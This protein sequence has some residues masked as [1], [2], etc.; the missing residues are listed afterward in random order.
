MCNLLGGADMQKGRPEASIAH[1]ERMLTLAEQ[2][3]WQD[4]VATAHTNLATVTWLLGGLRRSAEHLE[5]ATEIDRR[6]G[7]PDG[8]P[9]VLIT[10]GMTLRDLGRLTDSLDR[11]Q[12]AER[13]PK[14]LDSQHN[15]IQ[16]HVNLGWTLHLLGDPAQAA[17]H[18]TVGLTM[19]RERG[20]QDSEAY[21]LRLQ[22]SLHRDAGDLTTALE[23]ATAA[24]DLIDQDGED[25]YRAATRITLGSV[26][27]SLDRP[28]EADRVH[29]EAL[30]L[31]EERGAD[32]LRARALLGLA[33]VTAPP[34]REQ[35]SRALDIARGTEHLLVEAEALTALARAELLHGEA[36]VAA[37]HARDAL[38]VHRSTGHR[39][40]QADTLDILG[41]AVATTGE[42]D[43][44]PYRTEAA[45]IF[46]SL[47]IPRGDRDPR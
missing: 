41:R 35:I 10:L 34:D 42:E 9:V 1:L 26:L 32:D 33:A 4:G 11:L 43:P 21:A 27:L 13:A 31:A 45:E 36:A 38:A 3:D 23:L 12:R 39:K 17:H 37:A 24:R 22:A 47:G 15:R 44:A 40:A 46:R 14:D 2:A 29:R 18:L 25:Y 19:A 20:E 28:G 5:H 7:M 6:N 8:H 16:A 30:K